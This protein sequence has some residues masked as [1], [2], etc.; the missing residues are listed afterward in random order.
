[1]QVTVFGEG[2]AAGRDEESQAADAIINELGSQPEFLSVEAPETSDGLRLYWD[3]DP[4]ASALTT[5]L[6]EYPNVMVEVASTAYSVQDLR[7][8]ASQLL[9][10]EP[11]VGASYAYGDGSGIR[12][13]VFPDEISGTPEQLAERLTRQF[14]IPV[15]VGTGPPVPAN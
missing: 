11:G 3:G 13:E 15:D 5:L 2:G 4:P 9:K 10:T 7:E 8:I 6:R 1:M 14:G 12:V